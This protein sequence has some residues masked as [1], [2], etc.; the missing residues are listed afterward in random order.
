MDLLVLLSLALQPLNILLNFFPVQVLLFIS[1]WLKCKNLRVLMTG[2]KSVSC[3]FLGPTQYIKVKVNRECQKV[4]S[5]DQ[6]FKSVKKNHTILLETRMYSSRMRTVRYSG[7]FPG[8]CLLG[9]VCLGEC[10]PGG[11][12][13]GG[14]YPGGVC[15]GVCVFPGG[16]LPG[17]C[18]CP[19]DVCLGGVCPGGVCLRGVSAQE[20]CLPGGWTESETGV[21]TLSCRNYVVDGNYH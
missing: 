17:R 5:P 16:C 21:K 14:V 18:F 2:L 15:L 6:N 3:R 9:G 20:G 11:V 1:F 4:M 13:I 8:G 12:C 10:L 7:H 19:G